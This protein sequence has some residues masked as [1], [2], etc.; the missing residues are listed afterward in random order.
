MSHNKNH[1]QPNIV[2][3]TIDCWRG[4]HLD[5]APNSKAHTPNISNLAEQSH[6]FSNAYTCGGWTKIAMTSLFS[7]TYSSM[8]GFAQGKLSADRPNLAQELKK[9]LKENKRRP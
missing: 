2:L 8:H 5:L 4:D 7:S 9:K 6:Y 1:R 3:L